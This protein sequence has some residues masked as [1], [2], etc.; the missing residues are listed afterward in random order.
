MK[1]GFCWSIIYEVDVIDHSGWESQSSFHVDN[2]T[3]EEFQERLS[4]SYY[5]VLLQETLV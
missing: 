2:I 3:E 5:L 4:I 1:T